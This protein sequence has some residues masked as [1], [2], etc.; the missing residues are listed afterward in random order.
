[1]MLLLPLIL[2]VLCFRVG[3]NAPL[4]LKCLL[5]SL[6]QYPSSVKEFIR[7]ILL[8]W[9]LVLSYPL[10]YFKTYV[11]LIWDPVRCTSRR[12]SLRRCHTTVM[13]LWMGWIDVLTKEHWIITFK[14]DSITPPSTHD[15]A[16]SCAN[17]ILGY[18]YRLT[19]SRVIPILEQWIRRIWSLP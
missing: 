1:M 18:Y 11:V 10:G 8:W 9:I 17:L 15:T 19:P 6:M 13:V 3:S 7:P 5:T 12:W 14:V 2:H 4:T 16:L